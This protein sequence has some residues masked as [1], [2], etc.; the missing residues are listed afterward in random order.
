[1]N[2]DGDP[3]PAFDR[4]SPKPNEATMDAAADATSD[5]AH[6]ARYR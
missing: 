3:A 4:H 5:S 2:P 1:M 6:A